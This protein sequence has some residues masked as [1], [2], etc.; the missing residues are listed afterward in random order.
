MAKLPWY[1]YYKDKQIHFRRVWVF[2]VIAKY[3]YRKWV[4]NRNFK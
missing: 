1:M 2:I 3:Y 4:K